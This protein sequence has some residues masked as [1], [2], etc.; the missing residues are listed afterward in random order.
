MPEGLEPEMLASRFGA[1]PVLK[2]AEQEMSPQMPYVS[3]SSKHC[4]SLL[5]AG[6]FASCS[7]TSDSAL[8]A[9][10]AL[11]SCSAAPPRMGLY[12]PDAKDDSA[13]HAGPVVV[14]PPWMELPSDLSGRSSVGLSYSDARNAATSSA[15]FLAE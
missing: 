6:A 1:K 11:A 7:A 4:E 8:L 12:L 9:A 5:V 15:T 3:A 2:L 14:A 13:S 10:G